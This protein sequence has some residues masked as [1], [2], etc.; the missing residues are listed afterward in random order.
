M[1]TNQSSSPDS[2]QILHH[3]YGISDA[4]GKERGEIAVF[5]G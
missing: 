3:Q 4:S 5:A 1:L 2:V